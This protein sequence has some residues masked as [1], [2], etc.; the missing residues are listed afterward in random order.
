MTR[1]L[2]WRREPVLI[3]S[4]VLALLNLLATFEVVPLTVTQIG[5][6]N[7]AVAAVL[8]L[9]TRQAV[10]PVTPSTAGSGDESGRRRA[11]GLG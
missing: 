2:A 5:A 7:A 9:I 1:W 8:G 10:T 11:P 3:Q 6:A 4:A